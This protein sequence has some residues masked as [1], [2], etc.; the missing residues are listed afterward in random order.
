MNIKQSADIRLSSCGYVHLSTYSG[1]TTTTLRIDEDA[2][3]TEL[4]VYNID[5]RRL[6]NAIRYFLDRLVSTQSD[7]EARDSEMVKELK[8]VAKVLARLEQQE[9]TADA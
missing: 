6:V 8:E 9:A 2:S 5:N 4:A 7:P 1:D 3:N